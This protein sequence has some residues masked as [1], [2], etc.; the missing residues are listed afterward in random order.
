VPDRRASSIDPALA[1]RLKVVG[2]DVDGVLTDG[3]LYIG[4][5]GAQPV[6]LKRFHIQDGLG[7]KLLQMAGLA[8]VFVTA[9]ASAAT[10]ARA[11][12]LR[13]DDV[14]QDNRKLPAFAAL[15]AR[16]GLEWDACCFVGDD[17]PDLP[18]LR[19]VAW[20]VA[21]A[22]AVPEVLAAAHYTTRVPGGA[23]AVREVAETVLRARGA[24]DDVVSDYLRKRE[25][26]RVA[27]GS[28]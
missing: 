19:R 27:A 9:R 14:L 6:E 1:R 21:V 3:G 17:L 15:L 8:V 11:R 16:R 2:L 13:V 28:R 12:E 25:E 10:L 23:G 22:N 18:L 20:P 26:A 5:A 24:W 7:I 4:T